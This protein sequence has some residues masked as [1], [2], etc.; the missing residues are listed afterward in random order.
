MVLELYFTCS[1]FISRDGCCLAT[2]SPDNERFNKRIYNWA[3]TCWS[4]SNKNLFIHLWYHLWCHHWKTMFWLVPTPTGLG[5]WL[6]RQLLFLLDLSQNPAVSCF[7]P[8]SLGWPSRSV[9][10]HSALW[11]SKL[12]VER[13]RSRWGFCREVIFTGSGHGKQTGSVNWS[14]I[15]DVMAEVFTKVCLAA[16]GAVGGGSLAQSCE[17]W[18]L[19]FCVHTENPVWLGHTFNYFNV[20]MG[21]LF[22]YFF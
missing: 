7:R 4:S 13:S 20:L 11:E 17:V 22:F 18:G 21:F 6:I 12:S 16:G 1:W 2:S 14:L 19:T 5:D 10:G 9:W 8:T 15:R 3:E